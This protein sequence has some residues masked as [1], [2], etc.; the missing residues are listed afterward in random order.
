MPN[1]RASA[2][3][4]LEAHFGGDPRAAAQLLPVIYDELR[5][6]AGHYM[7]GERLDHTLQPT[8]LVHEAYLRLIDVQSVGAHGRIS[9]MALAARVLRNVLLD[10][11]RGHSAAKRGG[12]AHQVSLD[13]LALGASGSSVDLL[14]L[15][16]ALEELAARDE[17]QAHVVEL[18]YFGGLSVEEVAATLTVHPNTVKRDWRFARA[19]LQT[20]LSGG[21]E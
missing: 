12:G 6:L 16:G 20:R 11:A 7:R 21:I 9:F 10:H 18:R 19:W 3:K 4:S 8:A 15:H 1:S 14:A 2:T 17:R 5:Q 13:Q